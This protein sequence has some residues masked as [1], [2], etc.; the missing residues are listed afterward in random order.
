[1]ETTEQQ[2]R[3]SRVLVHLRVWRLIMGSQLALHTQDT[4][5]PASILSKT[6]PN[7]AQALYFR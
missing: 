1:L 5:Q 3:R 6:G 4:Q 7:Q 2:Q